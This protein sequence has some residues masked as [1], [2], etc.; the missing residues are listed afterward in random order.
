MQCPGSEQ[1]SPGTKSITA[2]RNVPLDDMLGI[3]CRKQLFLFL[4]PPLHNE[5]NFLFVVQKILQTGRNHL[6]GKGGHL[7]EKVFKKPIENEKWNSDWRCWMFVNNWN[8]YQNKPSVL[9]IPSHFLGTKLGWSSV[10]EA[11]SSTRKSS[12]AQG[13]M[14]GVQ[15]S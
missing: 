14:R 15:T 6:E 10:R 7:R 4:S 2:D 11:W 13:V 3:D 9:S 5:H 8:E 1:Q 12:S